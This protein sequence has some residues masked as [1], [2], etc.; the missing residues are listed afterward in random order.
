[1]KWLIFKTDIKTKERATEVQFLFNSH[2]LI[3]N[4]TIDMEDID[5]VL[6]V[7]A[8]EDLCENDVIYLIR[9]YGFYCEALPD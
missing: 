1:M 6:R 9:N 8:K 3:S 4:W 2:P 5:N 7:E